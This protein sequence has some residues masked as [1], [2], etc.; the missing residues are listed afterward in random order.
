ML[1]KLKRISTPKPASISLLPEAREVKVS[2]IFTHLGEI[3]TLKEI[4]SCDAMLFV[5]WRE[6]I[7][8]SRMYDDNPPVQKP[9]DFWN[10]QLYIDSKLVFRVDHKS[11]FQV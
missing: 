1:N 8:I 9:V 6:T 3:N 2:I 4:F 11:I 7:D 5:S 10:P